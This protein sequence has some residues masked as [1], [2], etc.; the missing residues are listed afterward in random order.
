[1]KLNTSI[2]SLVIVLTLILGTNLTE[3]A[4]PYESMMIAIQGWYQSNPETEFP[5]AEAQ[6]VFEWRVGLERFDWD[7]RAERFLYYEHL[8][9]EIGGQ[10]FTHNN[11]RY[12]QKSIRAK[13]LDDY[14]FWSYSN[15]VISPSANF[16]NIYDWYKSNIVD[17]KEHLYWL[18][19]FLS[20]VDNA[21]NGVGTDAF[22]KTHSKSLN[23][24]C[25]QYIALISDADLSSREIL[26]IDHFY[27]DLSIFAFTGDLADLILYRLAGFVQKA[28]PVL[29]ETTKKAVHN[30]I[31][32]DYIDNN[33]AIKIYAAIVD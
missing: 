13:M 30:F 16:S 10:Q 9:T 26:N 32:P 17:T 5:S 15:E 27:S 7:T 24:I 1:M 33:H 23:D 11:Y 29:T 3:A 25:Q 12:N 2:L 18:R 22:L 21:S 28:S 31:V 20:Y 4:T 6:Q 14:P 8:L 19:L